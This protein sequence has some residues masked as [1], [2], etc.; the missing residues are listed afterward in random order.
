MSLSGNAEDSGQS[1]RSEDTRRELLYAIPTLIDHFQT[2]DIIANPETYRE[3]N[4][5]LGDHPSTGQ[6]NA[7]TAIALG[8]HYLISRH[9]NRGDRKLWQ[10]STAT[11]ATLNI[12]RNHFVVGL[13][14][15]F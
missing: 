3:K 2:R 6:L 13:R 7:F 11:V 8:G 15:R 1:W 10:Y 14:V 9:L 4:V 12:A 5:I